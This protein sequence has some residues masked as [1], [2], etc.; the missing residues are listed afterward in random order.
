MSTAVLLAGALKMEMQR[1]PRT[2][3]RASDDVV[4]VGGG[5]ARCGVAW[6]EVVVQVAPAAQLEGPG[7]GTSRDK[8]SKQGRAGE[9]APPRRSEFLFLFRMSVRSTSVQD[10]LSS[11]N[12]AL[13]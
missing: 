4:R 1:S 6:R 5:V 2:I 10:A 9:R 12:G 3:V 8:G 13:P 7:R 11:H